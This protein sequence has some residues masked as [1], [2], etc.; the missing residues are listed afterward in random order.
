MIWSLILLLAI[1]K[2][3]DF[4]YC[5]DNDYLGISS[6]VRTPDYWIVGQEATATISGTAT[7][8]SS[9]IIMDLGV[10]V[11]YFYTHPI[12]TGYDACGVLLA[13]CP[14]KS[15]DWTLV[16]SGKIPEAGVLSYLLGIE[17]TIQITFG[18]ED[19]TN[20]LS[21]ITFPMT[22]YETLPTASPTSNP[23][24]KLVTY[25]SS[26]NELTKLI[27]PILAGLS[28]ICVCC[29]CLMYRDHRRRK[30]WMMSCQE[31]TE[32]FFGQSVPKS[33]LRLSPY[34]L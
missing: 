5:Q 21:C 3:V 32:D 16:L 2:E 31:Q 20:N 17:I 27:I 9:R 8:E 25:G 24:D 13:G 23:T 29:C 22:I 30:Q 14:L 34:E 10:V 33:E 15:G 19:S 1:A 7:L 28:A 4:N 18:N 6:F 12:L 11:N 26:S